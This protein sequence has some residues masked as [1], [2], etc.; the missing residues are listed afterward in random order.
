[1]NLGLSLFIAV[2]S[3]LYLGYIIIKYG[4]QKSISASVYKLET[5]VKKSLYAWF[6]FCVAL[7]MMIL[8]DNWMGVVAGMFLAFDFAAP[9]G[10]DKMQRFI[11]T[12]GANVGMILGIAMLGFQFG[13]WWLVGI[14]V[15]VIL[16]LYVLDKI[17]KI[18]NSVWWIEVAV[19]VSVWSGLL[20]E[21]VI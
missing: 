16:L 10:G 12:L 4:V 14:T 9:A 8:S 2:T 11:H 7:P 13:Q 6:I 15:F 21:K 17:N 1:M 19:L 20:I 18:R 5:S 3:L